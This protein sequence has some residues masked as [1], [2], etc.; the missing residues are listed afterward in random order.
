MNDNKKNTAPVKDNRR[1]KY[2]SI[3]IVF[4]VVF[5]AL[6]IALNLMLSAFS[7]S[8]DLTVDLTQEDFT[9]VGDETLALLKGL[10]DDLDITITFMSARDQFDLEANQYNGVNLTAMV[11]DL[12]ENY[13]KIFDGKDGKGIVRVQYKEINTDPEFEKKFLEESTTTLSPTSVI[14]EGKHHFRVLSMLAFYTQDEEG[15]YYS[16]NGE[17]RLTTAILQSSISDPQVVSFTYGHGELGADGKI[18]TSSDVAGLFAILTEAGFECKTVNLASEE[19]DPK[20]EILICYD[21]ETDF[22]YEETDKLTAYL[23]KHNSFIL[24][25]DSQ[26]PEMPA[27]QSLLDDNWGIGY[28]PFYRVTDTEHAI[29]KNSNISAKYPEIAEDQQNGSA[30]YQIRSTVASL[31]DGIRVTLPESV[32]LY[33]RENITRDDFSVE[34]V[35]TT[36]DTAVSAKEGKEGTK[37]EMPLMLLSTKYEYGENNVTEYSYVMLVGSTEFADTTNMIANQN[38]NR[39][40]MLATARIFGVNRVAPDID[41]KPFGDTALDIELGTAKLLTWLICTIVPGAII[42]MGLVVF[43]RRRHL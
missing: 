5:I 43:F 9:S 37:G 18:D 35:L 20:T 31:Q 11:R 38:G 40:V 13:A 21:P 19:I 7:L 28:K 30:A 8:G 42:V 34:T 12:A 3:S 23:G 14:V 15:K 6:I 32:E 33:K 29:G 41:D 27:L 39:R 17:Y 24:F 10:G 2:G 1:Y 36:Y 25:V 4:T 16:F 22:S 26:T